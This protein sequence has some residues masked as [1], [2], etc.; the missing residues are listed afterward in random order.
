MYTRI[1]VIAAVTGT[2]LVPRLR[3]FRWPGMNLLALAVRRIEPAA[4][5]LA[6]FVGDRFSVARAATAD[7]SAD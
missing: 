4:M 3:H 5:P 7:S 6:V 2:H 1:V